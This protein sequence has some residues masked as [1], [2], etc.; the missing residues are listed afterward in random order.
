M[1]DGLRAAVD[2]RYW[3]LAVMPNDEAEC[4]LLGEERTCRRHRVV[5]VPDP[6]RTLRQF[7]KIGLTAID[8]FDATILRL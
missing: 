1:T 4:P 5:S 3:H 7:D 8:I 6:K 2:V